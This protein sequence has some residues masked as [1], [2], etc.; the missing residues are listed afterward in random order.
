[1]LLEFKILI[2]IGKLL[3]NELLKFIYFYVRLI[4][5][6]FYMV[7]WCRVLL[8]IFIFVIVIDEKLY[9]RM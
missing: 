8:I 9:L 5:F 7:Y 2:G 6:L 4:I 3:I 1:M